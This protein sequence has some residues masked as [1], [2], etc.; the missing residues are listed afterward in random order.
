[1]P[2]DL[3]SAPLLELRWPALRGLSHRFAQWSTRR[4]YDFPRSYKVHP[5]LIA[6]SAQDVEQWV[7]RNRERLAGHG[8]TVA[9]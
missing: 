4:T 6:W 1:M 8:Q 2:P 5:R 7:S 3:L 9:P